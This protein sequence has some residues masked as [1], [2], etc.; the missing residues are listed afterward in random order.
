MVMIP[1]H[2]LWSRKYRNSPYMKHFS[3]LDLEERIKDI[4]NLLSTLAPNGK[5]SVAVGKNI[6]E[7]MWRKYTH[8]LCE[9]E[10]RYG[11]YPNGF[12]H[13]FI[14]STNMVSPTFP[15]IP[16]SKIA[17]DIAGGIV[18]GR[19]YKFSKK[20]YI[21]DMYR[22]GIFRIA[23]ASYYSD[24]SLNAAI[25]DDELVFNGSVSIS[26]KNFIKL[27]RITPSYGRLEYLVKARTNYYVSCFSSN[28]TYREF[29]DFEA[30]ACLIIKDPRVFISRLITAGSQTL[31]GYEGFAGGVKYLDPV[32]C[33][34]CKIDINFAK[35]F[36]YA[37]QN[38]YRAIWA[39]KEPISELQ[40]FYL[41]IGPLD[42]IA[43]VIEI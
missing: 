30:D 37:Y 11:P 4:F 1:R 39:P 38:E 40:A 32:L 5:I 17:I 16:A 29:S 26:L 42:D 20:K 15:N 12:T 6:N 10:D 34:P 19:L 24:P 23:P 35:H 28:Y 36:K 7:E 22:S 25:R 9:M 18:P 27:G 43:E 41:N 31:P 8:T 2:E 21:Y 33:D 3:P 14:E 13:G